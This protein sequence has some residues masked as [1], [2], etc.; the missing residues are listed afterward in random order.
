MNNGAHSALSTIAHT[1]TCITFKGLNTSGGRNGNKSSRQL[2]HIT[3][4]IQQRKAKKK[5]KKIPAIVLLLHLSER[6][7]WLG[8]WRKTEQIHPFGKARKITRKRNCSKRAKIIRRLRGYEKYSN[9]LFRM[10]STESLE[11]E[12]MDIKQLQSKHYIN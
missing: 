6:S 10:A 5:K 8:N 7:M 3:R 11:S 4:A 12:K 1:D 9:R 2:P